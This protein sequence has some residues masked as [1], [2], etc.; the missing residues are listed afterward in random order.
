M[1]HEGINRCI[2]D[3]ISMHIAMAIRQNIGIVIAYI[4]NHFAHAVW[5][6][7]AMPES[8]IT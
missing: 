3:W 4:G 8:A 2:I 7:R 5:L 1:Q 6:V